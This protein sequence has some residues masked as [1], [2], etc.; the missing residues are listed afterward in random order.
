MNNKLYIRRGG[1]IIIALLIMACS[2]FKYSKGEVNY[3][4]SDATWHTLLTV[5]A[6]SETPFRI[7]KFLPIVSLGSPDDKNIPWGACVP[8]KHGNFYYTSFSPVA[9]ILPFL[10]FKTFHLPVSEMSLYL[11]NSLLYALSAILWLLLL[12]KIFK[13][14]P[15]AE[16]IS[17]FGTIVYAFSPELFHGMGIVYWSQSVFQVS[18]ILQLLCYYNWRFEKSEKYRFLFY[19]FC[20]L[21]PYIEWSGF[22]ANGGFAVAELVNHWRTDKHKAICS[23]CI[24]GFITCLSF[25]LFCFHYLLNVNP[26]IF[27]ATVKRRFFA[28]NITTAV[29]LLSLV[30]GYLYSFS[31]MWGAFFVLLAVS[32]R[33]RKFFIES[34][35]GHRTLLFLT[36]F[37][38]LENLIMKEHAV[39]YTYDR[40]KLAFFI[41]LCACIL[42]CNIFS[43]CK[44]IRRAKILIAILIVFCGVAN[45]KSY[46]NNLRYIWN[47]DYRVANKQFADY[48]NTHYSDAVFGLQD[49]SV[50]GYANMLFDCGIYERANKENLIEIAKTKDKNYVVLLHAESEKW[51]LYKFT[52]AEIFDVNTGERFVHHATD[53]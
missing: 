25:A 52:F 14:S 7:H 27:F 33:K 35:T 12:Q 15:L 32:C 8:D 47:A 36:L 9:Y 46:K 28:R 38:V 44:N 23:F 21:N 16:Y 45:I 39:S 50:R 3:L 17:F 37:P 11:L 6:Y 34:F 24:I 31:W 22:V 26:R 10:F 49:L 2:A 29:R 48:I 43:N 19:A 4:N 41:S 18:F 5:Q 20:L 53:F 30:V 13:K 40:M 51:N 42:L 1:V